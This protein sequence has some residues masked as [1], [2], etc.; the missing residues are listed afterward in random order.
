LDSVVKV[1]QEKQELAR[2]L[3]DLEKGKEMLERH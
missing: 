3:V 2:R 1:A